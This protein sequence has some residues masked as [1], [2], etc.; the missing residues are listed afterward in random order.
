MVTRPCDG[1]VSPTITRMVVVLP[2]PLGPRKPVTRAG[3][4]GE[5]D[6]IDGREAAVGPGES[7]DFDHASSLSAAAPG[8]IGRRHDPAATKVGGAHDPGIGWHRYPGP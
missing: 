3:L 1:G 7:V 6:I 4:G 8:R 2:A 5:G